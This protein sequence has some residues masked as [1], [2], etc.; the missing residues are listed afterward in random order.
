MS[1]NNVHAVHLNMTGH[2]LT[3][4]FLKMTFSERLFNR[5]GNTPNPF[6]D[7]RFTY[8]P[9]SDGR[10]TQN[11]AGTV[12]P[13]FFDVSLEELTRS[14]QL[15][16]WILGSKF[17]VTKRKEVV[18]TATPAVEGEVLETR[19]GQ[20]L[21]TRNIARRDDM[22][23]SR[24]DED[25]YFLGNRFTALYEQ[26]EGTLFKP[27]R[28]T[29]NAYQVGKPIS[30]IANW[31]TRQNIPKGGIIIEDEHERWGVHPESY[32]ATYLRVEP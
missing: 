23:V 18:V 32:L 11:Y 13:G 7:Y 21:I 12:P 20:D 27:R 28:R 22:K 6:L 29:L 25:S 8:V 1:V 24:T 5:G 30:F 17:E 16:E 14:A 9:R 3:R 2:H 31:G 19:V 15:P 4:T 10:N 26:V